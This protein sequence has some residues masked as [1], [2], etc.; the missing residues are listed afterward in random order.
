MTALKQPLSGR[1]QKQLGLDLVTENAGD[2]MEYIIEK[3]RA[4]CK[5][6]KDIGRKTFRMEELR[7][8]AVT[9][10]WKMPH[11]A[12][13]WGALPRVAL[14]DGI[15]A[16]TGLYENATSPRTRSHPVKIWCAL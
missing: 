15:I 7:D 9:Q 11:H 16:F 3:L 5:V 4:F 8:V 13:A 1:E 2:W 10:Q 6:R 14:R 12:N